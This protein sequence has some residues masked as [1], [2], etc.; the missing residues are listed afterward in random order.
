MSQEIDSSFIGVNNAY[1]SLL[2]SDENTIEKLFY[3]HSHNVLL[4]NVGPYGSHYYYPTAFFLYQNKL[5]KREDDLLLNYYQLKGVKPF[6][7][8]SYMNASRKEQLISIKHI[9]Q[10]GTQLKLNFDLKKVSSPGAYI[11]QEANNTLFKS[12]L[13]YQSKKNNYEISFKN[14]IHRDFFEL[15]GGLFNVLDYENKLSDNERNYEVNLATSNSYLKKYKYDLEQRLDVFKLNTDSLNKIPVYVKHKF[16]YQTKTNAFFDN[17]PTSDIYTSIFIDSV[18]T[19][20]SV[21]NN[22][23]SNT[24][25]V[26]FRSKSFFLE[27]LY[28]Y[29]AINYFQSYGLDTSFHNS[30]VGGVFGFNN[31]YRVEAIFKYGIDG[32]RKGDM[33]SEI[34]I[35]RNSK[36]YKLSLIAGYS[37]TESDLK[38]VNYTSNHF[39]WKNYGFDKQSLLKAKLS[40]EWIKPQLDLIGET[41]LID[42]ALY[43]DTLAQANQFNE[44]LS[45]TSISL[46]KKYRLL[47]F[48]FKTALVYQSTSNKN[49]LPLPEIVWRQIAYYQ[50]YIFKKALKIQLG[51][52]VT[53]ST[54][55]YG[56]AFMPAL[57]EFY[58]QETKKLGYYPSVDVFL[59]THLKRAQIFLKYEHINAGG[60]LGK[61]YVTPSYPQ[62]NKSLKFGVSWN[63]F[64]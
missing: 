33:L 5:L 16:S 39:E 14:V 15:N 50:K 54:E 12:N 31:N 26:G 35:E 2:N 53:Y 64:D 52:G 34:N 10:L 37:L 1:D 43:Y 55:Y 30:Y 13:I 27:G 47:N 32:Y 60:S 38:F 20:D 29:D 25:F 11:N 24:A 59:N 57:Q 3:K 63:L 40:F 28:Q 62:L 19:V 56:Y 8:V 4:N 36:K 48:Y 45:M 21:Y 7:N 22:N 42:N 46:S 17:E 51:V 41:K 44:N 23:L 6:T 49:I 9:Q 58:V 61:S 18:G